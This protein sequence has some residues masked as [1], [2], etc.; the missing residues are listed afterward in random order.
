MD[1][2]HLKLD[3]GIA[4]SGEASVQVAASVW[5][6]A[7]PL[8]APALLLC[9]PGGNMN[10]HYF[11][12]QPEDGDD[13]FSFA[14]QMCARGFIVAAL[15]HLGLGDS[16]KPQDGWQ[17]TP[18]VLVQANANA[19]AQLLT[20]LRSGE[21]RADV[22]AVP[23]LRSVGVGHS[24]GAMLTVL[25]QHAASQHEAIVV[26]GF[27]TRGLPEYLPPP[28]KQI[29]DP[30]A[31]RPQLVDLARKM[32]GGNPYPMIHRGGG[33]GGAGNGGNAD[34]FGSRKADPRGVAALKRATDCVLPVPAVLSMLP[35]NVGAEAATIRC[36]VFLGIGEKD[37]VG[38]THQ[39]P[40]AFAASF[41][42][43]LQILPET[44]HSHFLFPARTALFDRLGVWV[45]TV[46]G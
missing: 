40:A 20:T 4:L 18:E 27:S 7:E 41:D 26:L 10:R 28:L 12:L 37:M 22:P 33:N 31:A 8:A 19:T 38:P 39:V 24:M 14:A 36:P 15:D 30:V 17:L 29:G 13:S 45:E 25:Q 3:S 23:G 9:L 32:F 6:P 5:L 42:V 1:P 46:L 44:G 16:T 43:T 11:D 21:L 2:I 34:L 35:N